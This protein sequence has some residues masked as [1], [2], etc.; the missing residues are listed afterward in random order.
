MATQAK[1]LGMLLAAEDGMKLTVRTGRL[2]LKEVGR[3]H[4]V[5]R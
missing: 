5:P 3:F 4:P 2:V 1:S